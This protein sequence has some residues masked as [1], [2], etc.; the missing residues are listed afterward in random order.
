MNLVN[1]LS[2]ILSH[3]QDKVFSVSSTTQFFIKELLGTLTA[4]WSRKMGGKGSARH[5]V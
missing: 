3:L 1:Q 5:S 4:V 2:E